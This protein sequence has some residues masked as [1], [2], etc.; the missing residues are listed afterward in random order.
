MT[1]APLIPGTTAGT[2]LA[3]TTADAIYV[4]DAN[5]VDDLIGRVD[6]TSMILFELNG[7]MPSVAEVAVVNAVLVA[8]MEHGLTPSTISA[9]LIYSSSPDALQGAVA[10]G[11]LGAG[12]TFLG[13]MEHLARLLQE[14]VTAVD[15][16]GDTFEAIAERI[17]SDAATARTLVPGFGHHIHQ[18]D[19]PRTPR[20]LAVAAEH[21]V[22]GP[23]TQLLLALGAAIDR[24]KGKHITINTTGA[25]A[26]VISDLGY[27]WHLMRGFSV[28]ARAAG[29]V[30]HLK[31]ER[32]MPLGRELWDL[33]ERAV[34]YRGT[35]GSA[36][37]R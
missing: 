5:L 28:I 22:S 17:V 37:A 21:G 32:E 26:A 34:P 3:R 31:E 35:G 27:P 15:A 23:H 29:I 11:L 2:A 14:G 9:R 24:A 12:S 6:F 20:L 33:V 10:A 19:D 36:D 25:V 18:P 8:L 4:R 30:A 16:D 13:S 7:R 1:S